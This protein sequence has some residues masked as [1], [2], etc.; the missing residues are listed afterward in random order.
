M[1][2]K[3]RDHSTRSGSPAGGIVYSFTRAMNPAGK[4]SAYLNLP[5]YAMGVIYHIGTFIAIILFFV[6]FLSE[7]INEMMTVPFAIFLFLSSLCGIIILMKRIFDK[8]L[9]KLSNPDDY[10]SNMLVTGFQ[11]ASGIVLL[12]PSTYPVYMVITSLLLLYL[13]LGKLKHVI[14]FFAARY[15]I[16]YFYGWRNVWYVTKQKQ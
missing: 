7:N 13:P 11:A 4:E 15:H 10:I 14:Y 5:T 8:K 9:R 1:L 16:G 12:T 3:P 6:F 2:G